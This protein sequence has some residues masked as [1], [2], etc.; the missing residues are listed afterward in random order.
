MRTPLDRFAARHP[1]WPYIAPFGVFLAF[2]VAGQRLPLSVE[3]SYP[4]RVAATAAAA[5]LWSRSVI[6]F[7]PSRVWASLLVGIVAF[8]LW[9]SPDLIWP[10]YRHHWLWQNVLT[11]E[12]ASSAPEAARANPAFLFW[13]ITGA[14][15]VVPVI[16]ELFWRVWLM[17]YIIRRDFV[18]VPL[19]TYSAR[20]FWLSAALFASEHGPFWDVGLVAGVI[21][22]GWMVR[23]RNLADCILAHAATNACLVGYVLAS[24][25]W[26]YLL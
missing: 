26:E 23:T 24:G 8:C 10:G 20:A 9:V 2:L 3:V 6:H 4:L 5:A 25:R 21:Y 13:R 14:V 18:N 19:G 22:N 7:R 1:S 12:L 11:G 15:V 17:R 16:E